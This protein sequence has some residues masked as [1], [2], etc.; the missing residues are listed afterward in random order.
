MSQSDKRSER[1]ISLIIDRLADLEEEK[2]C[3][4]ANLARLRCENDPPQPPTKR[5]PT[6]TEV[7]HHHSSSNEKIQL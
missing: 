7:V 1:E 5:E 3:L 4:N 6:P 2:R